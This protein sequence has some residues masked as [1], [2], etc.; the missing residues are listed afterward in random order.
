MSPGRKS[1]S[2][3][4]QRL[5]T[6]KNSSLSS[7]ANAQSFLWTLKHPALA[8]PALDSLPDE[9][10]HWLFHSMT[11]AQ[12]REAIGQLRRLNDHAGSLYV[13]CLRINQSARF[14]K[15]ASMTSPS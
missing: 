15:M 2:G 6:L 7:S 3:P 13:R 5:K 8:L 10:L 9:T 14:S 4:S 11:S 12:R 1:K